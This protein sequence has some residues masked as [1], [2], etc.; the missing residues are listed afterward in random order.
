MFE[1]SAPNLA[2]ME[3]WVAAIKAAISGAKSEVG[4]TIESNKVKFKTGEVINLANTDEKNKFV[5]QGPCPCGNEST[6]FCGCQ[7]QGYC[8][9]NCESAHHR[10]HGS[11][12]LKDQIPPKTL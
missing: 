10:Y 7:I 8:S 9:K 4:Y 5:A 11:V 3:K 12:C 1:Y 6:F 2:A